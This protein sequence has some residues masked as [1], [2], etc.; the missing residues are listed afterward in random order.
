MN[1][2]HPSH[3]KTHDQTLWGEIPIHPF[4]LEGERWSTILWLTGS[5]F[6]PSHPHKSRIFFFRNRDI[7][8]VIWFQMLGSWSWL[9]NCYWKQVSLGSRKGTKKH[10][11]VF[12]GSLW[13]GSARQSF[14]RRSCVGSIVRGGFACQPRIVLIHFTLFI[15]RHWMY[16]IFA[17]I[18]P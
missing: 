9:K 16:G 1:H 12:V 18:W 11:L 17:Y 7:K 4:F 8:S 10:Q 6:V 3:S 14:S 2:C 5:F 13:S 15:P